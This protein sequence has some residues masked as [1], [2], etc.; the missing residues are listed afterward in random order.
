VK[1]F[2]SKNLSKFAAFDMR[3]LNAYQNKS[4]KFY[5]VRMGDLGQ[6]DKIL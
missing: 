5:T 6:L 2:E 3:E 1:G 4:G